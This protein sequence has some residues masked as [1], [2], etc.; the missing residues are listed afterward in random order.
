MVCF[1]F[2]PN[3]LKLEKA[4]F[5]KISL[6]MVN[7]PKTDQFR[8]PYFETFSVRCDTFSVRCDTFSM[9]CDTFS[10]RCDTFFVGCDT[11]I[12]EVRYQQL[13][14]ELCWPGQT[15]RCQHKPTFSVCILLTKVYRRTLREL[16]CICV[17]KYRE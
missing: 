5:E 4:L 17:T 6:K 8:G 3:K 16:L 11:F 12:G 14:Q 7:M 10:V 2:A 1:L 13:I 9:R 15:K